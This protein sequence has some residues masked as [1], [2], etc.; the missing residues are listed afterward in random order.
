MGQ[1]FGKGICQPPSGVMSDADRERSSEMAIS[2]KCD[3]LL[4]EEL[5]LQS[6]RKTAFAK[7]L[8]S[9]ICQDMGRETIG[10]K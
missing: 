1:D 6:I 10:Q 7:P 5:S 8:K 9:E 2:F 4:E 3:L